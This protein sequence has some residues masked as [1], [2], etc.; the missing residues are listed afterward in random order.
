[1]EKTDQFTLHKLNLLFTQGGGGDAY[2][3]FAVSSSKSQVWSP[4]SKSGWESRVMEI[5]LLGVAAAGSRAT[6]I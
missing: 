5:S 2:I 6:V 3:L 4:D 1:M